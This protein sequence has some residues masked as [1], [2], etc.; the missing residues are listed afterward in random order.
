MS[1]K[2][3]EYGFLFSYDWLPA[4]ETLSGDDFKELFLALMNRQRYGEAFPAFKNEQVGIYADIF[5]NVIDR[6]L[7]GK[8]GGEKAKFGRGGDTT[9]GTTQDTTR[10][11]TQANKD[12]IIQNNAVIIFCCAVI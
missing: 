12:K 4:F 1:T 6:R 10:D 9:Q 7:S 8:R 11:T 5:A 2:K 3:L